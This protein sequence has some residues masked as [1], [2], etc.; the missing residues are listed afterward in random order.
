MRE[1]Y[2]HL[3]NFCANFVMLAFQGAL[4]AFIWY[5]YYATGGYLFY[6]R[7]HWAAIG[8]YMLIV[9]FFTR[10]F[11]GYKIGYLRIMDICLSHILAI[12]LGGFVGYVEVCLIK[13]DYVSPLPILV[14]SV[15]EMIFAI[16]WVYQVRHLYTILYPPR[17][18]IFIYG[19]YEPTDLIQKF[20]SREDKYHICETISYKTD[21]D[22][23]YA[24]IEQY[25]A[26][27]LCDLPAAERNKILKYCYRNN[28]RVYVT[29]KISDIIMNGADN[30]F[31]FDTPLL[32]CRNRG[33]SIEQ[34]FLKRAMDIVISLLGTII[35]SPFMLIIAIAIKLYDGGP[36]LYKQERI[37]RDGKP[38]MI[39]KFRSMSTDSEAKGARLAMKNDKR[40]TPVGKI[41]RNIHFDELP[42]LFNI[43]K[44]EMSVVGPRP[45]RKVIMDEYQKELPE[46][47]F[48]TKVKAGLTG[49]AQVF[50][51]YNTSPYDKLK[52]DMQYIENYSLGLD[53]KIL[54]LT[55]KILF[56]KENTEGVDESQTTALKS[57]DEK[58]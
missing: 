23:L 46:F 8:I 20:G 7:G 37:T 55:F 9:F 50:G 40:V 15:I 13:R 42:Q 53:I 47:D 45:E 3:L 27:M 24:E 11:N 26:V 25:Q 4:F 2:K 32:L 43:L 12:L 51:K 54:I 44:G 29:P 22:K 41:I 33:L 19:E 35:A 39:Y 18:V 6:R 49:Y 56:Q 10:T 31:L 36:V 52:F 28:I 30:I 34:R 38:F 58:Q 16:F 57:N 14:I 48:R 1:Q 21:E 5:K 17:D